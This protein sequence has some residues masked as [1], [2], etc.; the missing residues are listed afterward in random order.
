M[1]LSRLS[2]RPM[3]CLTAMSPVHG[4]VKHPTSLT[5]WGCHVPS[6]VGEKRAFSAAA[7][8]LAAPPFTPLTA[9]TPFPSISITATSLASHGS[10]AAS[11]EAYLH[12]DHDRVDS[13]ATA[14][15]DSN[16]AIVAH[17]YMD[18]ELQS[19]LAKLPNRERVFV[20]DSLAMGDAAVRMCQD[21]A[22][23]IICL[24][25]D[26][27]SESVKSIM[28]KNGYGHIPVLRASE[29]AIGCSLAESAESLTYGAWLTKA[30][31]TST[32]TSTN[33]LHVIYINTSLETKAMSS[34]LVPTITCTSSNVLL[35]LLQSALQIQDLSVYY[36][37][38]TFMGEN[39]V[40]MFDKVLEN[41]TDEEIKTKLHPLHS[42]AT[43]QK[44]RDNL[45]VYPAGNCV[46]HHMF[47]ESVVKTVNENYADAYVSAHLEVPGEMFEV[48]MEK[49]LTDKGVVGSTADIL[50][51][52][53]RKVE[54]E[55]AALPV[56]T[57]KKNLQVSR[58]TQRERCGEKERWL[59]ALKARFSFASIVPPSPSYM[60]AVFPILL[61]PS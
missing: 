18:V 40:T 32:E 21:G 54:E 24:G 29:K 41:W 28:A 27:M 30:A 55:A 53:K 42:R 17:F 15:K 57:E 39:L 11:Q 31:K 48:A 22:T 6:V 8:P 19:V 59:L 45:H 12:P 25:V 35:T 13:L 56:G 23:S 4:L 16:S 7:A 33:P 46:V 44:L 61:H 43:I 2:A 14:L 36:G 51:F 9:I 10:F 58:A 1:L 47:N 3:A 50:N 34:I 5:T 49:S 52:I 37:P 20:S 38:D 60:F 26:F